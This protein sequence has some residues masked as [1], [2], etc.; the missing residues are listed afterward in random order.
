MTLPLPVCPESDVL[1]L[2]EMRQAPVHCNV[3]WPTQA[4]A[5]AA[6]RGDIHLGYLPACGH[7]Y[8]LAFDPALMAYT[9][10][11]ENSLH[12]SARFQEYARRLAQDLIER[13][14]VRSKDVVEIGAGKGDF[15]LMITEMG[16]NRGWG[17]DPS[18]V[19]D[20]AYSSERVN[21]VLDFYS[22][23][24]TDTAADLI[25]CRHVLEHIED[26]DS[27]IDTVRRAVNGRSDTIVFFE[28]PNA[29]FTLR[30]GG[31][32]DV[33]YEHCSYFTPQSLAYLFRKHGFEVL[34]VNQVFGGQFLTIE[35]RLAAETA[36]APLPPAAELEQL[37]ADA[38]A[39][40]GGYREKVAEWRQRLARV[41]AAGQKAVIW[42][43]GS[44]G[45][46]FLNVLDPDRVIRYAVDINPRKQGK[47]IAGSGQEIVPPDFLRAYRPDVVVI[48]NRNYE[49][50]IGRMLAELGV[51]AE[52]LLA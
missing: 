30:H 13:Y 23:K 47:F 9:Q 18:Y 32:W 34:A 51:Q 11:Y 26:P 5:L 3:L 7:I 39:F 15:L 46:T 36:A 20:E 19:P 44:K 10:E 1:P 8:N 41:A 29:L 4:E 27:F 48:M 21:F 43:S 25:L 35:A 31:I 2:I 38:R 28:V 24:Y 17:F 16:E 14:D 37:T 49:Q 50:E 33:I 52:L 40:A 6:P 42:G 45:V 12:F 22:E